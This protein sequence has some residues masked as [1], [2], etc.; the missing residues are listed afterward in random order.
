MIKNW[1]KNIFWIVAIFLCCNMPGWVTA[2]EK[3]TELHAFYPAYVHYS[4]DMEKYIDQTDAI[5]FAWGRLYTDQ[6]ELLNTTQG[7]NGNTG[8]YYPDDFL[9]PVQYAK[10]KGKS[11]QISIFTD[12]YH[13][14]RILPYEE[15][16]KKAI[17]SIIR[18][19]KQDISGGKSMYFD[20][21]VIDF[22]GLRNT[23][24]EGNALLF[25]GYPISTYFNLF[26]SDLNSELDKFSKK[27]YVAVNPR[28]Y[29]DGYDYKE[30]IRIADKV[31]V[32]AHDYEPVQPLKKDEVVQYTGYNVL[33]P[34]DSLAPIGKIKY[35]LEDIR[36]STENNSALLNKIWLQIAFDS[37]QWR[38]S[39]ADPEAWESLDGMV[40]SKEGRLT[41]T[42]AMIKN[43]VENKD[44]QGAGIT[45]GYNE[46]L[47]SPY[48][49]YLHRLDKTHNIILYEDSQSVAAKV[50]L[51]KS[52]GLG[53]ISIWSV[54][55]IPDY[56]DE[57]GK[58][59]HLDVWPT[60]LSVLKGAASPVNQGMEKITF[61][62][63]MMEDTVRKRLGKFTGDLLKSDVEN[64]FRLALPHEITDISDLK[65]LT[66]LEYLDAG[67]TSIHTLAP[68]ASLTNLRVLYLQ[69]NSIIDV[70]PLKNLTKLQVLSLNGNRLDD[71]DTVADLTELKE[72]YLSENKI[73]DIRALKNLKRLQLLYLQR[74][75]VSDVSALQGLTEL[76]ELSLNGNRITNITPL[77]TLTL[78]E[79]LYM[80][81]NKI[82]DLLPLRTL[83]KLNTLYVDGNGITDFS[84]FRTFS[85]QLTDYDFIVK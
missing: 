27:L 78:L 72:L 25:N 44:G 85:S 54:G 18:L 84:V 49:E 43:R 19:L 58:S 9:K 8:F 63:K 46:E 80:R 73:R 69:R 12:G 66:H 40:L 47:Q 75:F 10:Q 14:Q 64:V 51:A 37:A 79:K 48:I 41:P 39:A 57:T 74:N 36:K 15:G 29:Y 16:R 35:A 33:D 24:V 5:S 68:L 38:F 82:R 65:Y 50:K 67:D 11:I 56:S 70:R 22:E 34:I 53:G 20:G 7:L 13:A 31:I 23:A 61:S 77:N 26:L 45:Y 17:A 52:Y 81:E 4:A 42:Y 60:L 76:R 6:A 62:N 71:I 2:Q 32:M 21:V 83:S 3:G 59:F 1:K 30:I 28:L 55:N